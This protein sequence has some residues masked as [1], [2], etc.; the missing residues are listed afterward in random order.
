MLRSR[1]AACILLAP[2]L[3]VVLVS[4]PG[5]GGHSE[6]PL[7]RKFFVASRMGDAT[8]LANLAMTNFDARTEGQVESLSI[9]SETPEQVV[10]LE[11][12]SLAEAYRAAQKE[13]KE[14]TDRWDTYQ[15]LNG[16]AIKRV[17]AA[18]KKGLKLKGQDGVVQEELG[19]WAADSERLAKKVSDARTAISH[20]RPLVELSMRNPLK[21]IDPTGYEGVLATKEMNISANVK[22]PDG[23][24]IKKNLVITL[25]QARMK[26]PRGDIAGNWIVTKIAEV[27]GSA[28]S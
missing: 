25:Q 20:E 11:L 7:V 16:D 14:F 24:S 21:P 10:P 28:K 26:G 13:E 4:T 27:Q 3:F 17:R 2:V 23:K 9:V 8:T 6:G 5:C 19:K 22:T 12:K 18:D 1:S 15:Q